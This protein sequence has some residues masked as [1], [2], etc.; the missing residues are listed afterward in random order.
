[1]SYGP[2]GVW[3]PTCVSGLHT[4][5]SQTCALGTSSTDPLLQ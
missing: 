3:P 1:M 4:Q 2:E 5:L